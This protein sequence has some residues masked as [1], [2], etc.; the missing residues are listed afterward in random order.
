MLISD[1]G[2]RAVRRK[3]LTEPFLDIDTSTPM[4]QSVI[5]IRAVLTQ[6][7]LTPSARTRPCGLEYPL[8]QGCVG[9]RSTVLTSDRIAALLDM[10]VGRKGV[11]D[12]EQL[13]SAL[14]LIDGLSRHRI[15]HLDDIGHRLSSRSG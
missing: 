8:P 3:S 9:G 6:L 15:N 11:G 4:G 13:L 7:R 10:S 14:L 5:G 2:M 12:I 1:L